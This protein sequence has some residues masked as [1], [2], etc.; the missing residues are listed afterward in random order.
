M[1]VT[2]DIRASGSGDPL[3]SSA[4][5]FSA[6]T[7]LELERRKQGLLRN[8][9]AACARGRRHGCSIVARMSRYGP[10][11]AGTTRPPLLWF[12]VQSGTS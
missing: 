12:A 2:R 7:G 10:V 11:V 6:G 9:A 1:P 3:Q 5:P 4:R 8:V